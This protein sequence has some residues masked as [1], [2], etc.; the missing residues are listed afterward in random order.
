MDLHHFHSS[1]TQAFGLKSPSPPVLQSSITAVLESSSPRVLKSLSTLIFMSSSPG[2]LYRG[3]SVQSYIHP[4][5]LPH[6]MHLERSRK[7]IQIPQLDQT[8]LTGSN[9]FKEIK[10]NF[11]CWEWHLTLLQ[12]WLNLLE[13]RYKG[14][15]KLAERSFLL[16]FPI[17]FNHVIAPNTT[18][19]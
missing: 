10:W 18:K 3:Q 9:I 19:P 17:N 13:A 1:S 2:W 14:Y 16:S 15:E 6:T 8:S 4:L 5:L 11:P 12:T 7:I